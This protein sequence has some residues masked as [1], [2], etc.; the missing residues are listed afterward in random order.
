[1]SDY[2][3]E[4]PPV[5]A[6]GEWDAPVTDDAEWIAVPLEFSCMYCQEPFEEGDNGCIYPTG[7]AAHRECQLRAVW[8]GIGHIVDH[9]R[10]CRSEL[11]TDAGLTMRQSSWLVWRHFHGEL[12]TDAELETIRELEHG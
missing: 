7:Y 2:Y 10:Y 6:F 3:D 12:V 5:R 1:V 11:G 4:L 9:A 8:G